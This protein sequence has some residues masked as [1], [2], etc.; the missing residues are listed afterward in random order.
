M[1]EHI[2]LSKRLK[3]RVTFASGTKE[4][5]G[6]LEKNILFCRIILDYLKGKIKTVSDVYDIIKKE[7][8][9]IFNLLAESI[10][11]LIKLNQIKKEE[12]IYLIIKKILPKSEHKQY[13]PK[14]IDELYIMKIWNTP[15]YNIYAHKK[16]NGPKGVSI[17][18]YGSRIYSEKLT[19]RHIP[20]LVN[21]IK[22]LLQ[23]Q[24]VILNIK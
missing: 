21:F 23:T 20:Y 13:I 7:P 9:L 22:M 11:F 4:H 16:C 17:A 3:K 14:D 8:Y 1:T 24:N 5:D 15:R 10:I 12:D 19:T 6:Q 18:R 2:T